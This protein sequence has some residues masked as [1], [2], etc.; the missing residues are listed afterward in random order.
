[1]RRISKRKARQETL[2]KFYKTMTVPAQLCGC[3]VWTIR[4][5]VWYQLQ[6]AE[7][8]YFRSLKGYTRLEHIRNEY[9]RRKL[10]IVSLNDL[11]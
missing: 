10:D 7:T 8:S 6:A 5:K 2:I 9:I 4:K 3:E 1:M 11:I